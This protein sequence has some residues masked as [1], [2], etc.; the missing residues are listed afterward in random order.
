[1]SPYKFVDQLQ[2]R[3][4]LLGLKAHVRISSSVKHEGFAELM[5]AD[6]CCSVIHLRAGGRPSY[7]VVNL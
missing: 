3:A 6:C 2:V 5:S 4:R 7:L 1:M